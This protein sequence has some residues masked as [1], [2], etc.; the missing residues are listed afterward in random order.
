LEERAESLGRSAIW[1]RP[2]VNEAEIA[3]GIR[4]FEERRQAAVE[5]FEESPM[6][7]DRLITDT[8]GVPREFVSQ[9][10]LSLWYA[11]AELARLAAE[12]PP[13]GA[14]SVDKSG[15][16]VQIGTAVLTTIVLAVVLVYR[17]HHNLK[18][19]AARLF[20]PNRM[21]R[22]HIVAAGVAL[23]VLAVLFPPWRL[24]PYRGP[25]R[26]GGYAPLWSPPHSDDGTAFANIDAYRL[27]AEVIGIVGATIGLAFVARAGKNQD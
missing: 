27:G 20:R 12:N 7:K 25:A 13:R 3:L 4:S 11:E 24:Q 14:V 23:L 18:E 21:T 17:P 10:S 15:L 1:N 22:Q 8:W 16:V 5:A 2:S 9:G 6:G 26:A 19:I